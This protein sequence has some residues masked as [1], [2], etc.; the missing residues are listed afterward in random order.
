M[1][2][3]VAISRFLP[4]EKQ[5]DIQAEFDASYQGGNINHGFPYTLKRVLELSQKSLTDFDCLGPVS[6]CRE[7]FSRSSA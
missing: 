2:T 5:V 1:A 7:V 3:L 4:F 6:I